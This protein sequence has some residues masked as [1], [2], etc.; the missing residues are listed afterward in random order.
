MVLSHACDYVTG[1]FDNVS[2]AVQQRSTPKYAVCNSQAS[3]NGKLR[4]QVEELSRQLAAATTPKPSADAYTQLDCTVAVEPSSKAAAA[5]AAGA[6]VLPPHLLHPAAAWASGHG[7]AG[8]G[9]EGSPLDRYLA[10][11]VIREDDAGSEGRPGRDRGQRKHG[12]R[13]FR[14]LR[15]LF[16]LAVKTTLVAGGM[17]AGLALSNPQGLQGVVEVVGLRGGAR[18]GERA[19]GG[20][21]RGPVLGAVAGEP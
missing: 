10:N 11:S 4:C 7:P 21:Q 14:P 8:M 5:A 6:P 15:L 19:R 1:S 9:P 17:G 13:R 12:G 20:E 16:G 3:E 18:A 2:L